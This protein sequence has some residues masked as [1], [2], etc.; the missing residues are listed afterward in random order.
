MPSTTE[1][2][3]FVLTEEKKLVIP[4][5]V[6]GYSLCE[7]GEFSP[8]IIGIHIYTEAELEEVLCKHLGYKTISEGIK[9]VWAGDMVEINK[10]LVEY[11][12]K[13]GESLQSE[14]SS[15]MKYIMYRPK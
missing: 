1:L 12:K 15:I 4:L 2:A 6:S 13:C 10:V 5:Y 11:E 9:K 8:L 7:N 14:W 3:C